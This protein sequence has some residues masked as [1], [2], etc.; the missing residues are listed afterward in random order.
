MPTALLGSLPAARDLAG[1][2]FTTLPSRRDV[3]VEGL[4]APFPDIEQLFEGRGV[5]G[6]NG[7][8]QFRERRVP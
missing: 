8:R 1:D 7:A 6:K 4:K 2:V 3:D 5:E